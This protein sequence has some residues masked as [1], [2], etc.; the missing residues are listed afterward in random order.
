MNFENSS[1][2][3]E[4]KSFLDTSNSAPLY[5]YKAVIHTEKEEIPVWD[6]NSKEV[7]RDYLTKITENGKVVFKMG[8]GDYAR[9]LYP[10]RDNLEITIRKIPAGENTRTKKV[11]EVTRYKAVFN[12]KRNP[13]ISGSDIDSIGSEQLN[14]SDIVEVHLEIMDRSFEP[15]RIKTVSGCF[16][17]IAAKDLITSILGNE[18]KKVTVDGKAA[19]DALDVYDPDRKETI[20]NAII[21]SGMLISTV[22]TY[23]QEHVGGVYNCGIGTFFQNYQGKRTWFV[24]PTFDVDR[25][26]KRGRKAIF[27]AIP[28]DKYPQLDSSYYEDGD[29]LKVVVTANRKYIDSAELDFVNQGSGF[30]VADANA[31]LKKPVEVTESGVKANRARL[32]HEVITKDRKDGL[33]Y[34]PVSPN[35]P[36]AN[37]YSARSSVIQR[38]LGQFDFVWENADPDLLFPGMPC[39]IVTLAKG[40]P[41]YQKGVVLFVQALTAKVE[42]YNASNFR[43][44]CRVTVA[45]ETAQGATDKKQ[46]GVVGD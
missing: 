32:N 39:R 33:N 7:V 5:N 29:V 27:Y 20:D 45:C 15:L 31:F 43:T 10:Y 13:V 11:T 23:I 6:L 35:G 37:I 30:R 42:K 16:R 44:Q 12:P 21:P 26:D 2:W 17:N 4:I 38:S 14:I 40:K 1:L 8:L 19:A 46:G 3:V 9:R 24:Y 36:S 41:I 18:S 34:A 28:Q 25:F 22:P